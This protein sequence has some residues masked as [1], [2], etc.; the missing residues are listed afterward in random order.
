MTFHDSAHIVMERC[1]ILAHYSEEADCLTR[2]FA[3]QAMRQAN[4]MFA[5]WLSAAGMSVHYDAVGNVIGRYEAQ[6]PGT[7][8]LLLGSHLDTV[9]N[10]G[11]YDG[12][13]GVMVALICVQRLHAAWGTPAICY[14]SSRIRGRGRS[15]LPQ[16]LYR[17]QRD[18]WHVRSNY[19]AF[20]RHQWHNN[21]GCDTSIRR[22]S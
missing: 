17:Q 9:Q 15:A 19:S 3:T 11:R 1:D 21:G 13:L 22:K 14:R 20:N 7:K 2:R 12:I 6:Q 16:C 18:D 5:T 10:A 4:D 8:T